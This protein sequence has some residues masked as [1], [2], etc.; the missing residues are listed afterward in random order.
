VK[1][2]VSASE[3]P[4][5]IREIPLFPYRNSQ[6]GLYNKKLLAIFGN[7]D[8]FGCPNPPEDR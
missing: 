5:F 6:Q 7:A 4:P 3:I 8:Y 2:T 1:I